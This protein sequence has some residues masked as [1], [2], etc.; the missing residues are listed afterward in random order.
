MRLLLGF[1]LNQGEPLVQK[2]KRHHYV[3]AWY[4]KPFTRES[5]K[6]Q[7]YVYDK[8]APSCPP[9]LQTRVNTGVEKHLYSFQTAQQELISFFENLAKDNPLIYTTHSPFLI[10][11]ER[12]STCLP[13]ADR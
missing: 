3:P 2:S 12:L 1:E 11:G 9:R 6:G 4:Q 10:D 5:T 8:D 13:S 7:L